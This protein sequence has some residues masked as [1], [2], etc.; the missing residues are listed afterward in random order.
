MGSMY[1][2]AENLSAVVHLDM[3][4]RRFLLI[5]HRSVFP[6]NLVSFLE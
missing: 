6:S 2:V 1:V 4:F 5:F 3:V